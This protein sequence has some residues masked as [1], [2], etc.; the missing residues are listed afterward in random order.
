MSMWLVVCSLNKSFWKIPIAHLQPSAMTSLTLAARDVPQ[1]IQGSSWPF[2]ILLWTTKYSSICFSC[3]KPFIRVSFLPDSLSSTVRTRLCIDRIRTTTCRRAAPFICNIVARS[4]TMRGVCVYL[5]RVHCWRSWGGRDTIR[6]IN[7][8]S[9][10]SEQIDER[11]RVS[12]LYFFLFF[13]RLVHQRVFDWQEGSGECAKELTYS[14]R[15]VY[16]CLCNAVAVGTILRWF[17][18]GKGLPLTAN[19]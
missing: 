9:N 1:I 8:A 6:A 3:L 17:N 5:C 16:I 18:F 11:V 15:A 12:F 19:L 14:T 10:P 7:E 4:E 2:Q 13:L